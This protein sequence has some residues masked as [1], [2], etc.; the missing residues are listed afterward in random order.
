MFRIEEYRGL[1]LVWLVS[2]CINDKDELLYIYDP[3]TKDFL[4]PKKG[5]VPLHALFA[6][7]LGNGTENKEYKGA[8]AV[9]DFF[10]LHEEFMQCLEPK[11]KRNDIC[12]NPYYT[13]ATRA[14]R[15]V[16]ILE[17]VNVKQ[18]TA[19]GND[20]QKYT[21]LSI[22]YRVED[23][24]TGDQYIKNEEELLSLDEIDE[25]K[26]SDAIFRKIKKFVTDLGKESAGATLVFKGKAY[27]F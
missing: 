7:L 27:K 19:C 20:G 1:Q 21:N 26:A 17:I 11:H 13:G 2:E 22:S 25:E 16:R 23:T 12:M 24:K 14:Y 15:T 18:Y 10:F 5:R 3:G 9:Q 4:V 8:C 6:T